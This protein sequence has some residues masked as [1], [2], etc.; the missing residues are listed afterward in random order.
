[1]SDTPRTDA[2]AFWVTSPTDPEM[3]EKVVVSHFA[4]QLERE[5][6]ELSDQLMRWFKAASPYATPGSLEHGLRDLRHA[7]ECILQR[8][9]DDEF[10]PQEYVQMA[11]EA[12]GPPERLPDDSEIMRQVARMREALEADESDAA[13]IDST[14]K[15]SAWD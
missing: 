10:I 3:Q 1:M 6:A 5:N 13:P 9:D 7:L 11:R 14:V 2:S 12:L 4:R 8:I 15:P